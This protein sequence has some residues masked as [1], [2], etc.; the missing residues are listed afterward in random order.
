MKAVTLT[1]IGLTLL[2]AFGG[3]KMALDNPK[4]TTWVGAMIPA[5]L[6]L[7]MT[8]RVVRDKTAY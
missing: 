8:I 4:W 7:Y 3:I 2:F 6:L 1:L 5:A